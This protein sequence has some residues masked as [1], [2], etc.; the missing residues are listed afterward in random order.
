[1]AFSPS[2]GQFDLGVANKDAKV[3]S[4]GSF[5]IQKNKERIVMHVKVVSWR[6]QAMLSLLRLNGGKSRRL[7]ERLF[8]RM[9]SLIQ[10]NSSGKI[11]CVLVGKE[12]NFSFWNLWM[13]YI[14]AILFFLHGFL[15]SSG[16]DPAF[17]YFYK[18]FTD[19]PWFLCWIFG[20]SPTTITAVALTTWT[21]VKGVQSCKRGY[22]G[23]AFGYISS[24][25]ILLIF[26]NNIAE[27]GSMALWA[28]R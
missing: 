11:D 24:V 8:L 27:F 1:V 17:V 26:A 25:V 4:T 10:K 2:S 22:R 18:F 7:K 14:S 5:N 19:I 20:P 12:K 21:L 9:E 28:L 3:R 16:L 23:H 13:I 6:K 15:G